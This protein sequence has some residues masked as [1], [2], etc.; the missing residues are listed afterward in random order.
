[1][2]LIFRLSNDKITSIEF[3]ANPVRLARFE[4]AAFQ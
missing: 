2:V 3:V 4:L 1:M